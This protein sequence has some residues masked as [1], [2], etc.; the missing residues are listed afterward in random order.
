[1]RKNA[2]L[3]EQLLSREKE[4]CSCKHADN[5]DNAILQEQLLIVESKLNAARALATVHLTLVDGL[6]QQ[7]YELQTEVYDRLAK[8]RPYISQHMAAPTPFFDTMA[9][10]GVH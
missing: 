6:Q 8:S 2:E 1:M 10:N 7:N 5:S 3:Q 4:L 9:G